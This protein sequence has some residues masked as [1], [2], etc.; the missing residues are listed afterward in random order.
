M[1]KNHLILLAFLPFFGLT[2]ALDHLGDKEQ[3]LIRAT[4]LGATQ[5]NITMTLDTLKETN[6]PHRSAASCKYNTIIELESIIHRSSTEL[7]KEAFNAILK[8]NS[9]QEENKKLREELTSLKEIPK[10]KDSKFNLKPV[11]VG[12]AIGVGAVFLGQKYI[13]PDTWRSIFKTSQTVKN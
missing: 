10:T 12:I 8:I 13:S 7:P 11:F 6:Q 9:L 1:Q 5:T 3:E 2:N 4:N